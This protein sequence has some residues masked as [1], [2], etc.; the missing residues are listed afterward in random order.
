MMLAN[1]KQNAVVSIKCKDFLLQEVR[2]KLA[3][4]ENV[5]ESRVIITKDL[6]KASQEVTDIS[7]LVV[8]QCAKFAECC[9]AK[10]D[11]NAILEAELAEILK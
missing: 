8:D 3:G 1:L 5:I 9:R 10:L 7:S 4:L 2:E 6:V 11:N